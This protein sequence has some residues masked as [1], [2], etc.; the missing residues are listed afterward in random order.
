MVNAS[1][2][3]HASTWSYYLASVGTSTFE[4][5]RKN[6]HSIHRY[7]KNSED[8]LLPFQLI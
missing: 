3:Q 7:F 2:S 8:H 4:E 1:A 5:M 6:E